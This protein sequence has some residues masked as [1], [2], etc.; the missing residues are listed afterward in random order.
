[1]DDRG[2]VE[3]GRHVIGADDAPRIT[4]AIEQVLTVPSYRAAAARISA[5]MSNAP[6]A[7]EVLDELLRTGR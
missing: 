1:M 7:D 2:S 4:A 3:R 5:E 6:T